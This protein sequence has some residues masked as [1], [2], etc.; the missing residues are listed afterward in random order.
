MDLD[1]RAFLGLAAAGVTGCVRDPLPLVGRSGAAV[2]DPHVAVFIADVHVPLP[3]SEQKYRTGREYPWIV[4]AIKRHVAEILAMNP[5]PAH[6]FCLGDIS[7]AFS[8]EKEYEIAAQLFKPIEDAGIKIVMTVGNHD[9]REPF[10]HYFSR[11]IGASPVDGRICSVTSLP[12]CDIVLLDSLV[13]PP[14]THRGKYEALT[15]CALGDAQLVWAKDYAARA[16]RPTLFAAHHSAQA[17]GI[18]KH[19]AR[20]PQVFGFL[21]GH[22]HRW[23]NAYLRDGYRTDK[24]VRS[25]GLPSFG[26]D[27][28]IGYAVARTAPD[29]VTVTFVERDFFFPEK[30]TTDRRYPLWRDIIRDN[31]GRVVRFPFVK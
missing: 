10:R 30:P 25:L 15:K 11:W 13:E 8:E 7:I 9:L 12:D 27:N 29:G 23:I 14:P 16:T 20:A 21:H 3:W 17:L 5:L 28:D 22:H 24:M 6:V 18:E 1:R 26:I 4:D 19:F 31:D 2:I